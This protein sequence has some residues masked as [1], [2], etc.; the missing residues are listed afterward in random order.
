M[1]AAVKTLDR[2]LASER[3]M[4]LN[5]DLD[6]LARITAEKEAVLPNMRSLDPDTRARLKSE[7][8]RNHVLLGAAMRGLREAIRRINAIGSAA[9]PMRTYTANGKRTAIEQPRMRTLEKRA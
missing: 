6:A 4:L 5:G 8:D 1:N 9:T 3:E 2:L 7:A